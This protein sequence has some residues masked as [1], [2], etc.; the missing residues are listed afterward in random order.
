LN[1]GVFT[2]SK[3]PLREKKKEK[4]FGPR[5]YQ[6]PSRTKRGEKVV[7]TPKVKEGVRLLSKKMWGKIEG[8][9]KRRVPVNL[10]FIKS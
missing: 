2:I 7:L 10:Q 6:E 5:K 9:E 4:S 3:E 8:N 1:E